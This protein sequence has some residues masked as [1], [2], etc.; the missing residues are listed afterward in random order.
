MPGPSS[1]SAAPASHTEQDHNT[2]GT[3]TTP[4]RP[5]RS[6][7][8]R[9]GGFLLE[10]AGVESI[11]G[12]SNRR[13]YGDAGLKGDK[14][15]EKRREPTVHHSR[16]VSETTYGPV[17]KSRSPLSQELDSDYTLGSSTL[18]GSITNNRPSSSQQGKVGSSE[19]RGNEAPK[20]LDSDSA[21]IVNLALSLN[22]SRRR[23]LQFS[24]AY[25]GGPK[26]ELH[27]H[28]SD[29]PSTSLF[30]LGS[31]SDRRVASEA[32][33]RIKVSQSRGTGSFEARNRINQEF[34]LENDGNQDPFVPII[35]ESLTHAAVIPSEATMQRVQR[36]KAALQ[37]SYQYRRL[38]HYLPEL[39]EVNASRKRPVTGRS[40]TN[41]VGKS[42]DSGRQ[43]NP[44]QYIRNR[45]ARFRESCPLNPEAEG[46]NNIEK[47]EEWVNLIA[48]Q[49]KT[50]NTSSEI[51]STLPQL[52]VSGKDY[53]PAFDELAPQTFGN[54]AGLK[55][56]KP[57][58]P[59]SVWET[60]PWSML[61]DAYWTSKPENL[62]MLEDQQG[63]KLYPMLQS[64]PIRG[65][66]SV[67]LD[68]GA[69]ITQPA[70]ERPKVSIDEQ[71]QRTDATGVADSGRGRPAKRVREG[72]SREATYSSSSDRRSKWPKKMLR[73]PSVS[74][75]DDSIRPGP[76][77][78]RMHRAMGSRDLQERALLERQLRDFQA[79][80]ATLTEEPRS[81][82]SDQGQDEI[83]EPDEVRS[84]RNA[85]GQVSTQKMASVNAPQSPVLEFHDM[86]DYEDRN[87]DEFD[88]TAPNSPERNP[89]VPN[90]TINLTPPPYD[91]SGLPKRGPFPQRSI[92]AE[93]EKSL[94]KVSKLD[95]ISQRPTNQEDSRQAE[96]HRSSFQFVKDLTQVGS[97]SR[98]SKGGHQR[99]VHSI[100]KT[101]KGH[102]ASGSSDSRFRGLLRGAKIAELVA[103][104]VTRVT[105]LIWRRESV[106]SGNES[107]SSHDSFHEPMR[108]IGSENDSPKRPSRNNSQE[109]LQSLVSAQGYHIR[110]LPIF[111]SP[112]AD[113]PSTPSTGNA[114]ISQLELNR[115][116]Q[117]QDLDVRSGQLAVAASPTRSK[118]NSPFQSAEQGDLSDENRRPSALARRFAVVEP[119]EDSEGQQNEPADNG[120][121][122]YTS[123]SH[124]RWASLDGSHNLMDFD[125][126]GPGVK[127]TLSRIARLRV[128]QLSCAIRANEV[129]RQA[130][131][132]KESPSAETQA[133]ED[134]IGVSPNAF[135]PE[136]EE[137]LYISRLLAQAIDHSFASARATAN[138][139]STVTMTNL[140]D[141]LQ[142]L[143]SQISDDLTHMARSAEK[144]ADDLSAQLATECTLDVKRLNE[145]IDLVMRRRRR[146]MRWLRRAGFAA[147]EWM[148]LGS[149]W[150]VWLIVVLVLLLRGIL[151][152]TLA[153]VKWLLWL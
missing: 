26:N 8:R 139:F 67:S 17:F 21:D 134:R 30:P 34:P 61:A 45:R 3:K 12:K 51:A 108:N 83:P 106:D 146:R 56:A 104:P 66:G 84:P 133:L 55:N 18:D 98:G 142:A 46:W 63:N 95:T 1:D 116:K 41:D 96:S 97:P 80:Q 19:R 36:A 16:A 87:F 11:K 7:L 50:S 76:R 89:T 149:M 94:Q 115:S 35:N 143:H 15:K 82:I 59:R 39:S 75:S 101:T 9:S 148:V 121:L 123:N 137:N 47:V 5:R 53:S 31:A 151:R 13:S 109:S 38:L 70:T 73:S 60:D 72:L 117:S 102:V 92:L 145:K 88:S 23:G 65:G 150:G 153:V 113:R 100:D 57:A 14:R 43:Y 2:N 64:E 112:F 107:S 29:I 110:N 141:R 62:R 90:F 24:G 122:E 54:T 91:S 99:N 69:R 20:S 37:L 126:Y 6:P 4:E 10:P 120:Q 48:E 136:L 105:D 130:S 58:R 129:A 77:R 85:E 132:A 74:S 144:G 22:E 40:G 27:R 93:V 71:R 78:T 86:A 135:I 25:D 114:N 147:L 118:L 68:L 124:R 79:R 119:F 44:L 103:S 125:L 111:R 32:F 81:P 28:A 42:S 52:P 49:R 127:A 138:T 152:G 33:E 131:I 140:H 128:V